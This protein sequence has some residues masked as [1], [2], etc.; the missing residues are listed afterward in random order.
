MSRYDHLN[1]R[2]PRLG[3]EVTFRYCKEENSGMP[4]S[5]TIMCWQVWFPVG[6]YLRDQLS[7][8]EWDRC[9]NQPQK[10]RLTT[11][12]EIVDRIKKEKQAT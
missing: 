2:C 3:G 8:D 10:D 7:P 1:I 5:R 6:T 9:F 12:F 11:I 4:C